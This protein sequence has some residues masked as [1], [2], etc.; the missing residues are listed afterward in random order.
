MQCKRLESLK[1]EITWEENK[2][3]DYNNNI[4]SVLNINWLNYF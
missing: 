3:K 4:K 2:D 1:L